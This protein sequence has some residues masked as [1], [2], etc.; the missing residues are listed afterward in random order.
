MLKVQLNP[1][2]SFWNPVEPLKLTYQ[3]AL[4]KNNRGRGPA[5]SVITL[6]WVFKRRLKS[7][8]LIYIICI[9]LYIGVWTLRLWPLN[10]YYTSHWTLIHNSHVHCL[11]LWIVSN[12][13]TSCHFTVLLFKLRLLSLFPLSKRLS[14]NLDKPTVTLHCTSNQPTYIGIQIFRK[15]SLCSIQLTRGSANPREGG[16]QLPHFLLPWCQFLLVIIC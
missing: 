14:L 12:H 5:I 8:I 16:R 11:E 3:V 7:N 10:S 1:G 6:G 13:M 2:D 9:I 4:A 15:Q